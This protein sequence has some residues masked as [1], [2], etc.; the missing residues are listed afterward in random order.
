MAQH[1]PFDLDTAL[2]STLGDTAGSPAPELNAQL[3]AR[4]WQKEEV[5]QTQICKKEISLWWVPMVANL[6]LCGVPALIFS[7]PIMPL[8]AHLCAIALAWLA[9]GGIVLT[10][11]ELKLCNLKEA[12]TIT[13]YRH[14]KKEA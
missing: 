6:I 4:L 10:F 14:I 9:I 11:I 8:W 13:L 1:K 2:Y 7:L 5:L 12:T 3:K